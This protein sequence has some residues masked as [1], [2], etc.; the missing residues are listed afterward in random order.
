MNLRGT[1]IKKIIAFIVTLLISSPTNAQTLACFRDLQVKI[2]FEEEQVE[3][4][5][6]G[7]TSIIFDVDNMRYCSKIPKGASDVLVSRYNDLEEVIN[8]ECDKWYEIEDYDISK[9]PL[10]ISWNKNWGNGVLIKQHSLQRKK[11]I[12]AILDVAI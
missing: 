2:N 3:F 1:G 4:A 11:W 10:R 12:Y 7:I 5:G 6:I 9:E 8:A